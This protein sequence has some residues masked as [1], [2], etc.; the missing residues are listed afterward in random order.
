MK[1]IRIF[2]I[3]LAYILILSQGYFSILM[4]LKGYRFDY[5]VLPVGLFIIAALFLFI[6]YR[7]KK[8]I[9]RKKDLELV[10]SLP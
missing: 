10:K 2:L 3:V 1:I 9:R 6:A 8:M 7:I 4:L 5:F